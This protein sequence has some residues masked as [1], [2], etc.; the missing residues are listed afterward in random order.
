MRI[1]NLI[2]FFYLILYFNISFSSSLDIP[3]VNL[4]CSGDY[5]CYTCEPKI[6]AAKLN[7]SF[8]IVEVGGSKLVMINGL[9]GFNVYNIQ[10]TNPNDIEIL[11]G[12]DKSFSEY[13]SIKRNNGE[14]IL[15]KYNK[16]KN[17]GTK[18]VDIFFVGECQK[19]NNVF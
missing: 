10:N 13:G 16:H 17:D 12:E 5:S 2:M 11:F 3:N 8:R 15:F 14:L 9:P 18:E 4:S 7:A 1:I 6:K 19:S